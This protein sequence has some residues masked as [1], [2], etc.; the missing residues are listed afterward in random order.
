MSMLRKRLRWENP[1]ATER[2]IDARITEWLER[3]PGAEH[4]DCPGPVRRWP[5]P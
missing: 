2:E 4:G 5:A 3:R 1:T